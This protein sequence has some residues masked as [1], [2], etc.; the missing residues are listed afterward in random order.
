MANV[1]GSGAHYGNF[2]SDT[3]NTGSNF[4]NKNVGGYANISSDSY[5]YTGSIGGGNGLSFGQSVMKELQE[6]KKR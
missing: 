1:I 3:K 4:D 5:K 2:S 6:K